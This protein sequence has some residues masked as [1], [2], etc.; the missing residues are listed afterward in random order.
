MLTHAL[1]EGLICMQIKQRTIDR[2]SM[3]DEQPSF[4]QRSGENYALFIWNHSNEKY[5]EQPVDV[6][7]HTASNGCRRN[8]HGHN[9]A[10]PS[11]FISRGPPLLIHALHTSLGTNSKIGCLGNPRTGY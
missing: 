11:W 8:F 9:S 6:L 4:P 3:L 7:S 1:L 2:H 10:L 5:T